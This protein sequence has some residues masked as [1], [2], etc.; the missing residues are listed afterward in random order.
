MN[1]G[2][3]QLCYIYV[4]FELGSCACLYL[5]VNYLYVGKYINFLTL[6]EEIKETKKQKQNVSK[7]NRYIVMMVVVLFD[8]RALRDGR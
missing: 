6:I 3:P 5:K 8:C 4:V 2:S 7:T 1:S